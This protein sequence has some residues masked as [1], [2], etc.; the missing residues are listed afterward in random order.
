MNILAIDCAT[1]F[2]SLAISHQQKTHDFI[3]NVANS[4]SEQIIKEINNLFLATQLNKNNLSLIIYNKGPGSFTG[5]RI[6]LSVAIGIATGLNIPLVAISSFELY[7]NQISKEINLDNYE[8][9]TIIDA[10]LNQLYIARTNMNMDYVLE[11]S[12]VDTDYFLQNEYLFINPE[13]TNII[14]GNGL[15]IY[16]QLQFLLDKK[17][18]LNYSRNDI[19]KYPSAINLIEIYQKKHPPILS[20]NNLEL[21]YLRD[22]VALNLI[23]QKQL[24]S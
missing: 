21:L 19:S 1:N 14:T 10:R 4:H 8:I 18:C 9:L 12:L 6:G 2:L 17:N 24:K 5:L 20:T 11:P 23:E 16:P 22:K 13:K 15:I 7:S 3:N